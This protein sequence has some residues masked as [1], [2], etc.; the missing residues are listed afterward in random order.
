MPN[1]IQLQRV[2]YP[3]GGGDSTPGGASDVWMWEDGIGMQ[4]ETGI[5]MSIE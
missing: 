5:F 4:W 1:P 3:A 2:I